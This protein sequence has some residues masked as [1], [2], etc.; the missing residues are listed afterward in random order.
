MIPN[1]T[2]CDDFYEKIVDELELQNLPR[3]LVTTYTF[4][5]AWDALFLLM[6]MEM[7]AQKL[8]ASIEHG[9]KVP[10]ALFMIMAVVPC[11]LH[12]KNCMVLK[13][14]TCL[15]SHGFQHVAAGGLYH[16]MTPAQWHTK[17]IANVEAAINTCLLGDD[18]FP[19]S[20]VLPKVGHSP[21][22]HSVLLDASCWGR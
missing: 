19:A 2:E 6:K 16:D 1:S 18:K 4:S 15:L 10:G 5:Q 17:F 22:S 20:C 11:I 21:L 14:L 12:A 3:E 8:I 7:A 13:F 9:T